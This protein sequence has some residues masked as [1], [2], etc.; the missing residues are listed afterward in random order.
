MGLIYKIERL[1]YSSYS[2]LIDGFKNRFAYGYD[3]I[4]II[5]YSP[6]R[7]CSSDY[8]INLCRSRNIHRPLRSFLF[9]LR[10][11]FCHDAMTTSIFPALIY[12]HKAMLLARK[13]VFSAFHPPKNSSG[14]HMLY[15]WARPSY[16]KNCRE[17]V[18]SL[19]QNLNSKFWPPVWLMGGGRSK[20]LTM[21]P[22]KPF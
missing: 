2:R 6:L 17:R 9:V 11:S 3:W 1:F 13:F 21:G 10:A 20:N 15:L 14:K 22:H 8:I 16:K 7:K 18:L 4:S 12:L 19:L 5:V